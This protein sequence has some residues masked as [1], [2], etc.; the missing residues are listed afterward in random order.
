M[1]PATGRV[2]IGNIAPSQSL[3]VNGN[4]RFRSIGSGAYAGVICRTSDGTLTTATS[5]ARQKNNV[6][7]L[8]NSL[9][10]VLQLRGISFTWKN[11]PAMGTRIGFIAQEF[12][13]VIPELVFTNKEDGYKG[14]NYAEI[15]ALLVEAI[16]TLK[17]ENEQLKQ[18][19]MEQN[20]RLEKMEKM[21]I[22]S[23]SQ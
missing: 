4:A 23:P 1:L 9:E 7:T 22:A 5:D 13:K 6:Q 15:S 2:G 16:K 17:A 20:T 12:E 18:V 14:I 19:N 11:D 8:Q 21:M 3:D 10:K